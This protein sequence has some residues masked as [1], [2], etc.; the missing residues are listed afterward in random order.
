M[1][2]EVSAGAFENGDGRNGSAPLTPAPDAVAVEAVA[3]SVERAGS[4]VAAAA[5]ARR[6]WESAL[7]CLHPRC[8]EAGREAA[9]LTVSAWT[10]GWMQDGG[11]GWG[12]GMVEGGA[13]LM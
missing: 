1:E 13:H 6:P 2:A 4:P 8:A 12:G 3:P 5:A 11:R 7:G 10:G 9:M